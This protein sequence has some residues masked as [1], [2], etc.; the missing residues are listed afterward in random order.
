[1]VLP[2]AGKLVPNDKTIL[3]RL[4]VMLLMRF[5]SHTV[6]ERVLRRGI[7]CVG[8]VAPMKMGARRLTVRPVVTPREG[9]RRVWWYT[10]AKLSAGCKRVKN[11][12]FFSLMRFRNLHGG[13]HSAPGRY[14]RSGVELPKR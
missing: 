12:V 14:H 4:R 10:R 3:D 1:M 11:L 13:D 9:A 8:L 2:L 6:H 7:F 5:S